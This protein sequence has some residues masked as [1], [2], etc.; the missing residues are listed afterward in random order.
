MICLTETHINYG[1]S[2]VIHTNQHD[3]HTLWQVV[4]VWLQQQVHDQYT[5]S[6]TMQ[7]TKYLFHNI[8]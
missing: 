7:Q 4:K 8:L 2:L 3:G 6:F 1:V 5:D